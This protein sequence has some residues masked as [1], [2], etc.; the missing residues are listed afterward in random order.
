MR[1]RTSSRSPGK[2]RGLDIDNGSLNRRSQSSDEGSNTSGN[3]FEDKKIVRR[4]QG[5][6]PVLNEERDLGQVMTDGHS[7]KILQG[8]ESM[9][10]PTSNTDRTLDSQ[11]QARQ[12]MV[13]MTTNSHTRSRGGGGN[14]GR[15]AAPRKVVNYS[16]MADD[17]N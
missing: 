15:D 9:L 3:S 16:K 11:I 17:S 1:P 8:K 7:I 2:N 13:L 6:P 14:K 4:W 12:R 5:P 10:L